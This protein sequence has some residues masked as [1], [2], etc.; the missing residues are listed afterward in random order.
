MLNQKLL[1]QIDRTFKDI[2]LLV[3]SVRIHTVEILVMT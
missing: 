3:K 1:I 2:V